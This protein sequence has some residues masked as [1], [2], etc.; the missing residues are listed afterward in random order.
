[1][2]DVRIIAVATANPP[3]R[4][5]QEETYEA[6][7]NWLP[8][9]E[10][11]KA[12]LERIFLVNDSIGYRHF[13]MDSLADILLDSQD[14]L[15]ARYRKFGVQTAVDAAEKALRQTHVGREG[16]GPVGDEDGV[17][18]SPAQIDAV[19]VNSCTGYLCPGL[20]SY[21]AEALELRPDVR[22][23]DLQGMGCGAALPNL[24]SA[25]NYLQAHPNSTV[26][27]I[28]VEICSA[29]LYFDEAPDILISNALFGDG[30][31]AV[32]LTNRPGQGGIQ[33]RGFSAGLYPQDREHLYFRTENSKLRNV[34]SIE[35]PTV[36]ARHGG[37][38]IGRL[39]AEHALGRDGID[40]WIVHPGGQKVLDAFQEALGL[41]PEALV[42]SRKVL[43]NYGNMS[44]ASV[45]F[46]LE[47]LLRNG[48]TRPGDIGVMCSFGA[49]F[50]AYAG[51]MELL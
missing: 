32:L 49:G 24:Q 25:Y 18:T 46:V 39:L 51:L 47:E 38:V 11:A 35:V 27:S 9:S 6:Y 1:V 29:T 44:S 15:I 14:A 17:P 7:V 28:A 23:F 10:R 2:T 21:V 19:I 5:S 45:L 20:T 31:A 34:L 3:L 13:G 36:G 4:V 12:L 16:A 42:A 33:L 40:H 50:G 48:V 26:L 22:P 37:E 43:Y 30:A 41:P 8:L